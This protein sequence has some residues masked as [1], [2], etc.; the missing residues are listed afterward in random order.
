[1]STESAVDPITLEVVKGAVRST[2]KEMSNLIERTSMSDIIREK[3]DFFAA[4]F[5]CSGKLVSSVD[6]PLGA[7]MLH[8]ILERYPSDGMRSGDLFWYNDCYGSG[9]GVS[10]SP[11]LVIA[12]P[13]FADGELVAFS[14]VW[15]HL[16]DIG[17]L[18][19]G[20]NS[21][22]STEIYHEGILLPPTRLERDGQRNEELFDTFI[23]NS[24]FP[25]V[26]KGDIRA[27][28]AST[29]LGEKRLQ[30][31]A[32]RFGADSL[33]TAFEGLIEQTAN[34]TKAFVRET[35]PDGTYT[36]EDWIDGD[37][38]Q[39]RSFAI[40]LALVKE[41]DSLT[42]DFSESDDQSRGTINFIMDQSV[43]K[44]MFGVYAFGAD[45]TILINEGCCQALGEVKLRDGS[46]LKP[47]FPAPLG[48][49]TATFLRVNSCL[50]GAMGKANDGHVPAS[51]PYMVVTTF[52]WPS[53]GHSGFGF[54]FDG[55]AV[56][57]GARPF[58]DG[59]DAIFYIGQR[60]IPVEYTEQEYPFR[61]E[62]YAL[63][64]DSGGPGQYR[65]GCGIV[66]DYRVMQDGVV[67]RHTMDN[68]LYPP[69]GIN[70]GC[71]GRS[72][73]FLLN[74]DTPDAR[75]LDA[76]GDNLLLS[77]GDV[78]R[79]MTCGGGGWGDPFIRDP[80]AVLQ[81]VRSG[82][83]SVN[84]AY[85]DYGVQIDDDMHIDEDVTARIRKA[86]AA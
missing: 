26:I 69:W 82:M 41:G 77:E 29:R 61:I 38:H 33:V 67:A 12:C 86:K 68:V 24:R 2:Q 15:G 51:F 59:H 27:L 81:D 78:L 1:M 20:S 42:F 13:V 47:R 21:P 22:L 80:Q 79:V 32:G 16:Q 58:A 62:Q 76:K 9:G 37:V 46:I 70:G 53:V 55:L 54:A 64:T 5:D 25:G 36:F 50:L 73:R 48:Q 66:R 4:V 72:G 23:R 85:E 30:E 56:G 18:A 45:Q 60:D 63:H 44:Q 11:D 75:E 10:H 71:D 84:A 57:Y 28:I 35:L 40:R 31:L 34:A 39:D 8:S 49:R 19:P 6:I 74:P 3:L 7:N 17:G 52:R 43:P 83:V 65:G 14:A